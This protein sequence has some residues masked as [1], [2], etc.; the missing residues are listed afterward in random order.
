[1]RGSGGGNLPERTQFENVAGERLQY[2]AACCQFSKRGLSGVID[3]VR[4]GLETISELTAQM[5]SQGKFG[6][7]AGPMPSSCLARTAE[8]QANNP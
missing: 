2:A 5:V 6:R 3:D 8:T 4:A 1:M 7:T